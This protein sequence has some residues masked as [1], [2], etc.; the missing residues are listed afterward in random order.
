MREYSISLF[1]PVYNFNPDTL[2]TNVRTIHEFVKKNYGGFE[3]IIIDDT[4]SRATQEAI[5]R[6]S[7]L[8]NISVQRYENG[9]SRRENLAASFTKA[10]Y[11]ILAFMDVD[12]STGL[13]Y[14][15][16]LTD[17]VWERN[18]V[19]IGSRYKGIRPQRESY[20]YAMS[21]FYN[22]GVRLLFGSKIKDHTCGFKAFRKE[23]ILGIVREMGYD[24]TKRRGWFWDAEMLIRAQKK[25]CNVREIPVTWA[26]DHESTFSLSREVKVVP[27]IVSFSIRALFL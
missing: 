9:P 12:L 5:E 24:N 6:A 27:Y 21:I 8:E 23:K 16:S 3:I 10:R 15:P 1:I 26:S 7:N 19:V 14:L 17:G 11:D 20:R 2:G 25:G 4:S 18:D 22:L 13:S